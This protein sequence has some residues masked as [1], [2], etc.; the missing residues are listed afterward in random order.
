MEC[1]GVKLMTTVK[2]DH[3]AVYVNFNYGENKR[4]AGYWKLN[5]TVIKEEAYKQGIKQIFDETKALYATI[6][7]KDFCGNY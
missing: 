6:Q 2:G 5:S 7:S 1:T 3:R 4:G